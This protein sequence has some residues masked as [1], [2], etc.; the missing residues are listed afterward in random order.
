[1]GIKVCLKF[2]ESYPRSYLVRKV[3]SFLKGPMRQQNQCKTVTHT[4]HSWPW[5][6]FYF[7]F[8]SS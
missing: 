1:M 3:T 6:V 2:L 8:P 7:F 4:P 5:C